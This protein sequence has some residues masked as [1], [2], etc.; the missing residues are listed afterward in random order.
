MTMN[1]HEKWIHCPN[2]FVDLY[3]M[4]ALTG[5]IWHGMTF[6]KLRDATKMTIV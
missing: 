3:M 1:D 4:H 5:F 6:L 2:E